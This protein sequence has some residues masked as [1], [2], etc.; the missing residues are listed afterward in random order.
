MKV[1]M[2]PNPGFGVWTSA[3]RTGCTAQACGL[4]TGQL[5][6]AL[7]VSPRTFK[8]A[9]RRARQL[10]APCRS[11]CARIAQ[12]IGTDDVPLPADFFE[13]EENRATTGR[14]FLPS[15]LWREMRQRVGD[16]AS[17][18]PLH[19]PRGSDV[20]PRSK[21]MAPKRAAWRLCG[22]AVCHHG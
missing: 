16:Q 15:D 18:M 17:T 7:P 8:G 9:G 10:Q 11:P 4:A 1:S 3:G 21:A 13:Q 6:W 14:D 22:F 12:R 2:Q 5:S 20:F 19:W